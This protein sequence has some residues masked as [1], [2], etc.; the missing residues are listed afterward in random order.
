MAAVRRSDGSAGAVDFAS[1]RPIASDTAMEARDV[2][3]QRRALYYGSEAVRGLSGHQ[4]PHSVWWHSA[5][6]VTLYGIV[7]LVVVALTLREAA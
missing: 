1:M 2:V 3:K 5:M 6:I 7:L 4:N